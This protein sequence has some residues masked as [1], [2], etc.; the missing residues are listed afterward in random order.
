MWSTNEIKTVLLKPKAELGRSSFCVALQMHYWNRLLLSPKCSLCI[1]HIVFFFVCA[2]KIG[3][4]VVTYFVFMH[5]RLCLH[6]FT[7]I[8]IMATFCNILSDQ[9]HLFN[10]TSVSQT[11]ANALH[12]FVC[13]FR[14]VFAQKRNPEFLIIYRNVKEKTHLVLELVLWSTSP[15]FAV[16]SYHCDSICSIHT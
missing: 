16:Y 9:I 12:S 2:A 10:Q 7:Q 1:S 15:S 4:E 6:L 5:A 14:P 3:M 11:C 8:R 13:L